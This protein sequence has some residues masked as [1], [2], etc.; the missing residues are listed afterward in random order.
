M[1]EKE[2][3]QQQNQTG[4]QE[5][6][7]QRAEEQLGKS[8]RDDRIHLDRKESEKVGEQAYTQESDIFVAPGQE[9]RLPHDWGHVVQQKKEN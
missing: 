4:I 2:E 3:R 8:F 1:Y 6:F 7:L 9:Q 5:V